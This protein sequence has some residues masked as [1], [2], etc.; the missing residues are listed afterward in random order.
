MHDSMKSS[1]HKY[2]W[3]ITLF[4]VYFLKTELLNDS[5]VKDVYNKDFIINYLIKIYV[6]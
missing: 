2:M 3:L 1:C 5:W 6:I 4:R